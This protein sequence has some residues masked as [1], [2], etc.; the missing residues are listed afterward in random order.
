MPYQRRPGVTFRI[1]QFGGFASKK[2]DSTALIHTGAS[3][4]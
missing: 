1:G 2:D 4:R 3:A